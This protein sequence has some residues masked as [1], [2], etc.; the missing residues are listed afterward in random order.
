MIGLEV[1]LRRMTVGHVFLWLL[2]VAAV[3]VAALTR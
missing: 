2:L 1:M 3:A